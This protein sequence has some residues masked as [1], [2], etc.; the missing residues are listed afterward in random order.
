[1]LS[2]IFRLEEL[3]I[4]RGEIPVR[5]RISPRA[6]S[7]VIVIEWLR[8]ELL[9]LLD[10]EWASFG[11]MVIILGFSTVFSPLFIPAV[12]MSRPENHQ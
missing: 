8:S 10:P 4:H 7:A 12:S 3:K 5:V 11:A 2:P 1:M 6:S 9:P